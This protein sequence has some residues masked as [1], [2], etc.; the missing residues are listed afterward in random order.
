VQLGERPDAFEGLGI[1]LILTA[2]GVLTSAR[3]MTSPQ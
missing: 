2:L 3:R 1:V